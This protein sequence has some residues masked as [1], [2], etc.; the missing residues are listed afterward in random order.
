[1]LIVQVEMETLM[2]LKSVSSVYLLMV[3]I[4]GLIHT[5]TAV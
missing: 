3:A 2:E 4:P 1:M 5:Q